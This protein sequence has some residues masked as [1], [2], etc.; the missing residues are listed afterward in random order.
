MDGFGKPVHLVDDG[1]LFDMDVD[2]VIHTSYTMDDANANAIPVINPPI[3]SSRYPLPCYIVGT[4]SNR[5]LSR[6]RCNLLNSSALNCCPN[7]VKSFAGR[8]N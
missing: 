5:R 3:P 1:S 8:D 2:I 6:S 4:C 7:G